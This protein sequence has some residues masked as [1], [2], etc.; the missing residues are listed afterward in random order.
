M[1]RHLNPL[2][3]L[4]GRTAEPDG[5]EPTAFQVRLSFELGPNPAREALEDA[6]IQALELVEETVPDALGPV[7]AVDFSTQ[8]VELDF[9]VLATRSS[10]VHETIGRVVQLLET[11][12]PLAS[13]RSSATEKTEQRPFAPHAVPAC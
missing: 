13:E 2:A 10:Q 9:T 5:D 6:S 3:L 12:F 8:E 1:P 7:A 11:E 4:R